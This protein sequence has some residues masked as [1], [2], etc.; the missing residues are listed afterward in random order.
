M[1]YG[2]TT[3]NIYLNK[4][5]LKDIAD[6]LDLNENSDR[7]DVIIHKLRTDV[8]LKAALENTRLY[9]DIQIT[10][11]GSKNKF[12]LGLAAT[13]KYV[14]DSLTIKEIVLCDN[15]NNLPT[16]GNFNYI[17]LLKNE[18]NVPELIWNGSE[19]IDKTGKIIIKPEFKVTHYE[20]RLVENKTLLVGEQVKLEIIQFFENGAS[21]VYEGP[22]QVSVNNNSIKIISVDNDCITIEG[23]YAGTSTINVTI[24]NSNIE[25]N[26]CNLDITTYGSRRMVRLKWSKDELIIDHGDSAEINLIAVYND[27]SEEDITENVRIF[28]FDTSVVSITNNVIKAIN[29][30]ETELWFN[31]SFTTGITMPKK[32]KVICKSVITELK[33]NVSNTTIRVGDTLSVKLIA[34]YSDNKTE[35]DVTSQYNLIVSNKN[36]ITSNHNIITALSAGNAT[37]DFSPHPENII[38]P[39]PLEIIVNTPYTETYTIR[40]LSNTNDYIDRV[41]SFGNEY[42]VVTGFNAKFQITNSNNEFLQL[43]DTKVITED[44]GTITISNDTDNNAINILSTMNLKNNY[45]LNITGD[46]FGINKDLINL[47]LTISPRITALKLQYNDAFGV[48]QIIENKLYDEENIYNM[49]DNNIKVILYENNNTVDVLDNDMLKDICLYYVLN[50]TVNNIDGTSVVEPNT[51]LLNL[52]TISNK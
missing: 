5:D 7:L 38:I 6:I 41:M 16:I 32:C 2:K 29:V 21:S 15:R 33:W 42:N 40:K 35:K 45:E 36:I 50:M 49:K 51:Y 13:T 22:M 9:G 37:L 12:D 30:G 23:V 8:N 20:C 39:S 25:N 18:E 44:E 1:K 43:L 10:N 17:Y 14:D 24:P 11:P 47:K 48:E 27:G 26:S 34:K 3:D 31:S 28:A 52:N 46:L 19:Y 4:P